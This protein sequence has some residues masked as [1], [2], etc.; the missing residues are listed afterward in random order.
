MKMKQLVTD[1]L[2][3]LFLFNAWT[4]VRA[5]TGSVFRIDDIQNSSFPQLTLNISALDDMGYPL[6]GLTKDN[7]SL[8][9][10]GNVVADFQVV[11]IN[12]HPVQV[13]IVLDLSNSMQYGSKPT[14]LQSSTAAAQEFLAGLGLQDQAAV[15]TFSDQATV[16]QD[17]TS[18][19]NQAQSSL[20]GLKT[21]SNS[22]LNDAIIDA[23]GIL[24]GKAL[25]PVIILLTDGIESG[26]STSS[27]S[28][29][30]QA[31]TD[32]KGVVFPI[33]WGG[34][35]KD[36]M[37]KL[38]NLTHGEAQFLQGQYPN[39]TAFRSA[40]SRIQTLISEYRTQYQLTYKSTLPADGKE[41]E[42]ALT[43]DHLGQHVEATR[44]FVANQG[45]V[46]ISFN[47]L[48]EGQVISGKVTFA[49]DIKAPADMEQL[50]ILL[51]GQSLTTLVSE[52]FAFE[53]DSSKVLP[54]EH[55][56]QFK[57]QDKAGNVGEASL[58]LNV[59]LPI[60]V[61]ITNPTGG[62][63]V[64]G[65]LKISAD[66][67]AQAKISRVEFQVDG[68]TLGQVENPPYEMNWP[69]VG[70]NQGAHEITV[71]AY[72]ANGYS[73]PASVKVNVTGA[74]GGIG[75]G[76]ALAIILIVAALVIPIGL[77]LRSRMK[78]PKTDSESLTQ[79]PPP[80]PSISVSDGGA[81]LHELQGLNPEYIWN[82]PE[83]GD[84]ALGRKRDENDIPLK[85][86]TASRHHAVIRCQEGVYYLFNQRPENPTLVNSNPVTQECALTPGD[87]IQAGE[88]LF[89]FELRS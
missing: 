16:A 33:T 81:V 77:R 59:E 75:Q 2:M 8:S 85:G 43:L 58:R 50:E 44:R 15:V 14:P 71:I 38:A 23:V 64:A 65:P 26:V 76:L 47:T 24:K 10:D 17:L 29:V 4:P 61:V 3:L 82:L 28:D 48:K 74:S 34:A 41:H 67:T 39:Q 36:D 66:V 32:L 84:I 87:T 42:L 52:P 31:I 68:T 53:W 56:F 79:T 40:F 7:F 73:T 9:E 69:A 11:P 83:S 51:D 13:V 86:A 6:Q 57:A 18:D 89:Q 88:S 78:A 63:N 12:Q 55:E 54:G 49:P 27:S 80:V 20:N 45:E 72:D 25:R 19:L 70:A 37:Q 22:A 30:L 1:A 21:G 35:R 62:M 5:Q 46:F 60:Q